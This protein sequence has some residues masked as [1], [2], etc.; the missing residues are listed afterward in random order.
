MG[1]GEVIVEAP[2]MRAMRLGRVIVSHWFGAPTVQTYQLVGDAEVSTA[3]RIGKPLGSLSFVEPAMPLNSTSSVRGPA[4]ELVRT[5]Q[6]YLHADAVVFESEGFLASI[7]RSALAGYQVL[8]KGTV[9]QRVFAKRREGVDWLAARMAEVGQPLDPERLARELAT[10]L[11]DR[12]N[13]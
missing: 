8:S 6:D 5:R 2:G 11:T 10:F 9:S 1:D 12:P 7:M 3:K 13:G 4:V